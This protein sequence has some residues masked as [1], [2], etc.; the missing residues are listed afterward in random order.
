MEGNLLQGIDTSGTLAERIDS[1]VRKKRGGPHT[2]RRRSLRAY[3]VGKYGEAY[4]DPLEG[5]AEVAI[6]L[7]TLLLEQ[8]R[9]AALRREY[10]ALQK[11]MAPY[12]WPKLR[13]V[14]HRATDE[15]GKAIDPPRLEVVLVKPES[16]VIEA[17][18]AEV[19]E[20]E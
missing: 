7:R 5:M 10:L 17:E 16:E 4:I 20:S 6:Y 13:S 19:V 12:L 8:P 2:I 9:N 18:A 1:P 15:E 11:E 3:L 14:E